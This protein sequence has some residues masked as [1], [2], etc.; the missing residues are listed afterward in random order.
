MELDGGVALAVLGGDD[1]T[2]DDLDGAVPGSVAAGHVVIY[3]QVRLLGL[4]KRYRPK[5]DLHKVS[6]A[7]LRLVSLYSRY[8]LWVPLLELYF[9]QKP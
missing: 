4:I 5:L 6:I 2:L 7:A 3:R 1:G 9:S 8:M